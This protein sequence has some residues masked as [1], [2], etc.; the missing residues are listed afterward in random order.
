MRYIQK[1]CHS[2][3]TNQIYS[4]NYPFDRKLLVDIFN[5]IE[6]T[7]HH[8]PWLVNEPGSGWYRRGWRFHEVAERKK[9][10]PYIAELVD[11]FGFE[12]CA[13][14]W[15]HN[16]KTFNF[17]VHTDSNSYR[18]VKDGPY[19]KLSKDFPGKPKNYEEIKGKGSLASLNVE[20][21]CACAFTCPALN[22][23][24]ADTLFA[25]AVSTCASSSAKNSSTCLSFFAL[26]CILAFSWAAS[27]NKPCVKPL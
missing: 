5:E 8:W 25:F 20:L 26:N 3:D 9:I 21:N 18:S 16:T 6:Y 24:M 7:T 22:C 11:F 15:F 19:K 1:K 10:H 13:I 27:L 17:P 23:D 12:Y 2:L 14:W 4:I